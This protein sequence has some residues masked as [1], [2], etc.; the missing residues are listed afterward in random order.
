MALGKTFREL[1]GQLGKLG[2]AFHELRITFGDKPTQGDV[3]LVDRLGDS[4]EDAAGWLEEALAAGVNAEK[5]VEHP[6]NIELARKELTTCQERFNRTAQQYSV[7]LVSYDR[8]A[9]LAR[10]GRQRGGEWKRWAETVK[11]VL[12]RCREPLYDAN[13]ALFHCWQELVER[14]GMSSVSVQ[15][16]NIGQQITAPEL[17]GKELERRGVT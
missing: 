8:I 17:A 7:E 11:E 3:A 13:Q 12:E 2:E 5:A 1:V 16:T 10:F 6:L 4:I 14:L 15:T 9:E